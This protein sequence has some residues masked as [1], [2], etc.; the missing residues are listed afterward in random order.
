MK[1]LFLSRVTSCVLS[2]AFACYGIGNGGH[3]NTER[4]LLSTGR[5]Q[6]KKAESR[7]RQK[8]QSYEKPL[9]CEVAEDIP[10]TMTPARKGAQ[11]TGKRKKS[12]SK[13]KPNLP[14]KRVKKLVVTRLNVHTQ[15]F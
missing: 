6:S 3:A 15:R 1:N 8:R 12:T 2:I 13:S 5:A 7:K 10:V 4:R 9:S 14:K 11:T